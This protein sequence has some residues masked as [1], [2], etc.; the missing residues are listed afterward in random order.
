MKL[1]LAEDDPRSRDMLVRRLRRRGFEVL[2]AA[3]GQQA[4]DLALQAR[5]Q[6]VLMDIAM[7]KIDGWEAMAHIRRAAPE[8]PVVVLSAHSLAADRTRALQAGACA[9]L[10]KPV[11]FERLLAIIGHQLA[12]TDT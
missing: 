3:D 8:I 11:D 12:P 10:S 5:P 6:L 2:E 7:P 1:L 4:I 9:Y